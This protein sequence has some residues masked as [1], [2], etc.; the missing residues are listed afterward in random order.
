MTDNHTHE[1]QTGH[2]PHRERRPLPRR[3]I[4]PLLL[5]IA[6]VNFAWSLYQLPV[7]RVIESRL[8]HDHYAA[9]DPSA[10][11]PDGTVPEE[12][13][14]IDA[15]QMS[16]GKI[17]GGME[18]WV[19]GGEE[20]YVLYGLVATN[21]LNNKNRFRHDHTACFAGWTSRSS[22]RFVLEPGPKVVRA[23]MDI[24]CWVLR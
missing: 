15:V 19:A 22:L 1:S 2:T 13:C 5:L 10:L 16:L 7:S 12:L 23:G 18:T 11:R 20:L 3:A 14:K 17:Q 21:V 4:G 24:C 6:L 9:H 8:C